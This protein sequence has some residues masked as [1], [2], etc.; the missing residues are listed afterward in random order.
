MKLTDLSIRKLKLT[1][2]GRKIFFDDAL[3]GFGV[4]VSPRHKTFVVLHGTGKHRQYRTIGRYPDWSLSDARS[5]AKKL[6]AGPSVPRSHAR[7]RDAVNKF[8]ED[9]ETR[10]RRETIRQYK[11][12]LNAFSWN[13]K[14]A[15]IG[16]ANVLSHLRKY[17][18]RPAAEVHALR[19][20]KVFFNW[21][22][23]HEIVDR[24]PI[25]G[26][27]VS[28]APARERYLTADEIRAIWKYDYPHYSTIVKL[29]LLTGQRRSEVAAI[30][31]DWIQ[32]DLLIFPATITKNKRSHTIPL[33][34]RVKA[35][36]V[37]T[38][39]GKHGPWNGWANGKRRIDREVPIE[40]WTLHDLRRTYST[41]MAEIGT[42]IHVTER[43]LN[44]VSGTVSGVARIY[45]R[46]SYLEE[47]RRAQ[48]QYEA[49]L[50][51][52]VDS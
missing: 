13:R 16:R 5:E 22:V 37:D 28:P 10:N 33:S 12:Y 11:N 36:L 38:P 9:C 8:L 7:Y 50:V 18:G 17:R 48:A 19:T 1:S 40:H 52:I 31:L 14:V 6:L 51:S 3:G 26:E 44:H 4:R 41:L 20:L 2:S 46:Y 15:D 29:C 34:D 30:Q 42:P 25:A 21:C 35:L 23:R 43:L 45:N 47:M 27:R 24:N 32:D 49:Y 39:F